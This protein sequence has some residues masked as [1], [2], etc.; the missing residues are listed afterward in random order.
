MDK[1]KIQD[2]INDYYKNLEKKVYNDSCRIG[3]LEAK[4]YLVLELAKKNNYV[5]IIKIIEQ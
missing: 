4:L 2:I 1:E 3:S 5:D